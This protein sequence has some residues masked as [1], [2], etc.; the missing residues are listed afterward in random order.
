MFWIPVIRGVTSLRGREEGRKGEG[1]DYRDEVRT[2]TGHHATR[3]ADHY[4]FMCDPTFLSNYEDTPCLP[5]ATA[6]SI[7]SQPTSY[8]YMDAVPLRR[9]LPER[10]VV[11]VN[12]SNHADVTERYGTEK[13]LT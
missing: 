8:E 11:T 5:P 13:I 7:Y 10:Q 12:M 4:F 6:Q 1:V 9:A 3:R 2:P